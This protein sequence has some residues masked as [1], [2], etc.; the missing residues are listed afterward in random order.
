MNKNFFFFL[1]VL[2]L[3]CACNENRY[4][5]METSE[6]STNV[7]YSDAEGE[8]NESAT[9]KIGPEYDTWVQTQYANA[10][11]DYKSI[12]NG[13]K[14]AINDGV[15][16]IDDMINNIH[17]LEGIINDYGYQISQYPDFYKTPTM[18]EKLN[19]N[20]KAAKKE[21]QKRLPQYRKYYVKTASQILWKHDMK[22]KSSGTT[23]WFIGAV[24]ARNA[25]IQEF[26]D[27]QANKLKTLGFKR[28]CYKWVDANVEYTYYDL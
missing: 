25:N 10:D 16:L 12:T 20:H 14:F 9:L 15:T 22:V 17:T 6:D 21:L 28:A 1:F 24:F 13:E 11:Y 5:A 27:D 8:D 23:I 3:M 7:E 26:H 4:A 18:A 2:H 19:R